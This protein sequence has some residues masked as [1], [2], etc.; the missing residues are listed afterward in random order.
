V[1]AELIIFDEFDEEIVRHR[2]IIARHALGRFSTSHLV[3]DL[4]VAT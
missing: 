1:R 3:T 4:W 2:S